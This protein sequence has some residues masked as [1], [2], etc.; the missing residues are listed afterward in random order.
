[1]WYWLMRLQELLFVPAYVVYCTLRGRPF[2]FRCK[3]CRAWLDMTRMG[4]GLCENCHREIVSAD[5]IGYYVR[6]DED[7]RLLE[8]AHTFRSTF[9]CHLM[10]RRVARR[11]GPGRVLDVGCG[12]G[13]LFLNLPSHHGG[14]YG[15]D[16]G[17]FDVYRTKNWIEEG[18]FAIADGRQIPYRSDTFDYVVCTEVLEHL[19]ADMG[20]RIVE[21]CYRVLRPGGVALFTVPN[22]SGIAGR[23]HHQHLR[24][25]TF[26]SFVSLLDNTGFQV[27]NGKKVGLYIPFVSRLIELI[28]GITGR[29]LPIVSFLDIEV[30]ESLS[31]SFLIECRKPRKEI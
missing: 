20:D 1:M 6:S 22:G 15:I 13:Y 16:L 25:F 5:P 27:I 19:P 12:P 24:Q 30:P 9:M 31:I 7:L 8:V 14:L 28:N 2:Y 26:K 23:S 3:K 17:K 10:Y 11:I 18:N 4:S 29:R 21:E